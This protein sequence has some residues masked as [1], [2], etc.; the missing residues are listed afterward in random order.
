MEFDLPEKTAGRDR[1]YPT[2]FEKS[3]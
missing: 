1:Q 3:T 2:L